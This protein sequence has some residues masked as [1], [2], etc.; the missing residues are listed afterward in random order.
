MHVGYYRSIFPSIAINNVNP[1]KVYHSILPQLDETIYKYVDTVRIHRWCTSS[2]LECYMNVILR[3]KNLYGYKVIYDID[4]V[5]FAEDMPKYNNSRKYYENQQ[6]RKN[7]V[8]MISYCDYLSCSTEYLRDYYCYKLGIRKEQ[9]IVA[10]NCIPKWWVGHNY[11]ET[12]NV[13]KRPV[14][15]FVCS[16]THVSE[17]PMIEDDFTNIVP[18]IID[19]I[20]NYQFKFVGCIPLPLK[21]YID[22]GKIEFIKFWPMVDYGYQIA[23]QGF[24]M[25]IMPLKDSVFN[26]SK[27]NIK[28][29]EF[30]ASGIPIITSDV[31]TYNKYHNLTFSDN[32]QLDNIINKLITD[33]KFYRQTIRDNR[34]TI[35]EGDENKENGWWIEN[36]YDKFLLK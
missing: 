12:K 8:D 23:K 5:I 33:L 16:N 35:D 3:Y 4:D 24:D 29:L 1:G 14:I 22:E 10:P 30:W 11:N 25:V 6:I 2:Q 36:N 21:R 20:N 18:W 27:S 13:H 34:S 17:N 31:P 26:R 32:D 15:G 7:F 28:L 19:N 9:T